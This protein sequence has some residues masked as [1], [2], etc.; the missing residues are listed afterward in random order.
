MNQ[1]I[2]KNVS[3]DECENSIFE[4]IILNFWYKGDIGYG[5]GFKLYVK[6]QK[7]DSTFLFIVNPVGIVNPRSKANEIYGT[8]VN[9]A[10]NFHI[11]WEEIKI[12]LDLLEFSGIEKKHLFEWVF[13]VENE[14]I[15]DEI[16]EIKELSIEQEKVIENYY[17]Q[18]FSTFKN[19]FL[20]NKQKVEIAAY[21]IAENCYDEISAENI[22]KYFKLSL[23][24]AINNRSKILRKFC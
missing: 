14:N 18:R 7:H 13:K 19:S 24:N 10:N 3:N 21:A 20:N 1:N 6:K 2:F 12:I 11:N 23:R 22:V 15:Q 5:N 9:I 8:L 17:N 16:K 4:S